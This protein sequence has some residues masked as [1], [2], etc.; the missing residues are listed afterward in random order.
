MSSSA[1]WRRSWTRAVERWWATRLPRDRHALGT[2]ALAAAVQLRRPPA[3]CIH[4]SDRAA[5]Y[6]S[7]AYRK[8]MQEARLRSSI[9]SAGNPY[10]N[11]QAESFMKT[12]K[13]EQV[14][15]AGYLASYPVMRSG[16]RD[17]MR[18][19]RADRGI[20]YACSKSPSCTAT[21][22]I[23]G[24]M[25]CVM[26]AVCQRW[27]RTSCSLGPSRCRDGCRYCAAKLVFGRALKAFTF[28]FQ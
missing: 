12:P 11:A 5:P 14:Y 10:H 26:R 1:S 13:V 3:G 2:G 27:W 17:D 9:S 21:T 25:L 6:A 4:H 20:P 16:A 15:L 23:G 19:P 8:A 28:R 18:L 22:E 7:R 24:C